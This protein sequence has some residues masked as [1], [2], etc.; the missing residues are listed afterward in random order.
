V[1]D[2]GPNGFIQ[3]RIVGS[4]GRLLETIDYDNTNPRLGGHCFP[5]AFVPNGG[6]CNGSTSF[7]IGAK[8]LEFYIANP[9][10]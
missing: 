10:R 7:A 5:G 3:T 2:M 6:A 1:I 9:K 8:A 4:G